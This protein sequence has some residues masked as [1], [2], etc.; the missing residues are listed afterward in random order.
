MAIETIQSRPINLSLLPETRVYRAPSWQRWVCLVLGLLCLL[1]AAPY[2]WTYFFSFREQIDTLPVI[3]MVIAAFGVG[4]LL[5]AYLSDSLKKIV[6]FTHV[7]TEIVHVYA[8]HIQRSSYWPYSAYRGVEVRGEKSKG[9]VGREYCIKL[10]HRYFTRSLLL[11][12]G[13][14]LSGVAEQQKCYAL[15]FKLPM[16]RNGNE[17]KIEA[18]VVPE[19]AGRMMAAS[20]LRLVDD[21]PTYPDEARELPPLFHDSRL[22]LRSHG[23]K[24]R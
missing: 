12:A 18:P 13:K 8:P 4:L 22:K 15:A 20:N 23:G 17:I 5:I 11:Q 1:F 3:S 7:G 6:T 19:M 9:A 2:L 14:P 21:Q 16:I 24:Y 10:V